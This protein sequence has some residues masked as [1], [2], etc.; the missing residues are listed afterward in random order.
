MATLDQIIAA[1]LRTVTNAPTA[2]EV[3]ESFAA[4]A[5][6]ARARG[7]TDELVTVARGLYALV[8]EM[9]PSESEPVAELTT[10][11][12]ADAILGIVNA[13]PAAPQ[14]EVT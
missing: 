9:V 1:Q 8:A 2:V 5:R 11:E 13:A 14:E 3:I 4:F 12:M 6:D 10:E 7:A